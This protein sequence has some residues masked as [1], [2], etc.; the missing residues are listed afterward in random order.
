MWQTEIGGDPR[1][2]QEVAPILIYTPVSTDSLILVSLE[3]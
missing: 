3:K 1:V 2:D